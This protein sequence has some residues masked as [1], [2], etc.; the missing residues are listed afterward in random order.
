VHILP[1]SPSHT[2]DN[3]RCIR[4]RA[5]EIRS[6]G[7][8]TAGRGGGGT[9]HAGTKD[10]ESH[11]SLPHAN[12]SIRLKSQYL[13]V[14]EGDILEQ[15]AAMRTD[16]DVQVSLSAQQLQL[17]LTAIQLL[18][19]RFGSVL[20]DELVVELKEKGGVCLQGK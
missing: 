4:S 16:A 15:F 13:A 11:H 6:G 9:L 14:Q 2:T 18:S 12:P 3:V 17:H 8:L 5:V 19:S 7:A 20:I 1:F 10:H